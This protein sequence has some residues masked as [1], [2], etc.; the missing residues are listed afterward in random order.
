M[1]AREIMQTLTSN[2]ALYHKGFYDVFNNNHYERLVKRVQK[3][4]PERTLYSTQTIPQNEK[5]TEVGKAVC[6]FCDN[7][8]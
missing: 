1:R 3:Q 6:L 5:K 2:N 8:D 7:E 4:S